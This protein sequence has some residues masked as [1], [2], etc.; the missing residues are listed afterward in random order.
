LSNFILVVEIKRCG[1]LKTPIFKAIYNGNYW[2]QNGGKMGAKRVHLGAKTAKSRT[3]MFAN[4]QLLS[5][6]TM[7]A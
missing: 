7:V 5:L 1:R 6:K 3:M 4:I 2:G